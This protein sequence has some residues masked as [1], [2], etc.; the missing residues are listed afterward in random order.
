MVK[1]LAKPGNFSRELKAK[2]TMEEVEASDVED[3]KKVFYL[4][5]FNFCLFF[6]NLLLLLTLCTSCFFCSKFLINWQEETFWCQ[7]N[8]TVFFDSNKVQCFC[9]CYVKEFVK[10]CCKLF[11]SV[12]Q[13]SFKPPFK[14]LFITKTTFLLFS[15]HVFLSML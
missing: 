5:C 9:M 10:I 2:L 14:A 7:Q 6:P 8:S 11:L 13:F 4:T 12:Y 3:L 15:L 1:N